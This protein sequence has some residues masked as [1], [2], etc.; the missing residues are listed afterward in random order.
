MWFICAAFLLP[1][2][3]VD[4]CFRRE[5]MSTIWSLLSFQRDDTS[6]FNNFIMICTQI[7]VFFEAL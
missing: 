5:K 1:R 6:T 3:H 4:R 2:I 7:K